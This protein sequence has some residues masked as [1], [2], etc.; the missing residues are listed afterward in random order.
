MRNYLNRI[1]S[2][3]LIFVISSS[4]LV[5]A[6]K[7]TET[8]DEGYTRAIEVLGG[9]NLINATGKEPTD[10]ITRAEFADILCNTLGWKN[11]STE[12]EVENSKYLGYTNDPDFDRNG[13]WVWNAEPDEI[14]DDSQ[15]YEYATPF[16]DVLTT[17]KYWESIRLVARYGLMVGSSDGYFRPDEPIT[18]IEVEKVLV[19]ACGAEVK[20]KDN[21]PNGIVAEAANR[22]I[23]NGVS[24]AAINNRVTYRDAVIMLYNA[25]NTNV[26][27]AVSY[28]NE[29]PLY[30]ETKET[31]LT[32]F[33]GI[34]KG[35]GII[36]QNGV[37]SLNSSI[38]IGQDAVVINGVKFRTKGVNYDHLLGHNV[39]IYYTAVNGE[40]PEVVFV[41]KN[42]KNSEFIVE[43]E[44]IIGYQN[45]M[46]S[47]QVNDERTK[48]IYIGARTNI[49]Y[50]GKALTD[51][52]VYTDAI[53]T[54]DEGYIKFLD[55]NSD[56]TY[57][58]AFINDVET[59]LVSGI[60]YS[61]EIIYNK[62]DLQNPIVLG[63]KFT[64]T[65]I[66]G[67]KYSLNDIQ[68]NNVLSVQRTLATQGEPIVS[69]KVSSAMVTGVVSEHRATDREIEING[70]VYKYS[71]RFDV[72]L[73]EMGPTVTFYLNAN[74]EVVWAKRGS[75]LIFGFV[76]DFSYDEFKEYGGVRIYDFATSQF[77]IY[78]LADKITVN[79][80]RGKIEKIKE[81]S[82]I[83]DSRLQ[84]IKPQVIK[85]KL[86]ENGK[87]VEL[88]TANVDM[89]EFVEHDLGTSKGS[90]F[91]YR[92]DTG[93]LA[94]NRPVAYRNASTVYS[95]LPKINFSDDAQYYPIS[96]S[97]E[98]EYKIDRIFKNSSKS[99]LAS[100]IIKEES[101]GLTLAQKT[102]VSDP[103]TPVSIVSK[104]VQTISEEGDVCYKITY[105]NGDGGG[106]Y[107]RNVVDE[108]LMPIAA[109][110]EPG[111]II[112]CETQGQYS[113]I[114]RLVKVM[115]SDERK[116][117]D[118][119]NPLT[120]N[121]NKLNTQI[122]A[123]HGEVVSKMDDGGYLVVAPYLYSRDDEENVIIT[124][125]ETDTSKYHIYPSTIF[126]LFIYDSNQ[127]KVR[128]ASAST[129]I[130]ASDETGIGSEVIVYTC[131]ALAKSIFILK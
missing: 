77:V 43:A 64:L 19:Y 87:V 37:T 131:Y 91:I 21:F 13:D 80:V 120:N 95:A 112:R 60:D 2:L 98:A 106:T 124:G 10:I 25:L 128:T 71:K 12:E 117:L 102:Q 46:L 28:S 49:I 59:V 54:P 78:E 89:N 16:Y 75:E 42:S 14:V 116:W 121:V 83:Y 130:L 17:H 73:I 33:R 22:G 58:T 96:M 68:I 92:K 18:S 109:G 48:D 23:L 67:V 90:M 34:Y 9:L 103:Y 50:N 45:G 65:D 1:I 66:N 11:L 62:F 57:E 44:D 8:V 72:N 27:G 104:V 69:V 101:T 61:Q 55:A 41:R 26:F 85:Y 105:I 52:S 97:A 119:N 113:H 63:D 24:G 47:Y 36:S 4:L 88:L 79:K 39:E 93:M 123:V 32:H 30:Q 3:L 127:N 114:V 111:D 122:T 76:T 110:L 81:I 74:N 5:F 99:A 7:T 129:D 56:G 51:Y 126:K 107:S 53:I 118:G 6:E 40:D 108:D 82:A 35:N 20:V 100:I 115:D 38:G 70:Q 31:L 125:I 86:D 15:S 94:T 84:S 29:G